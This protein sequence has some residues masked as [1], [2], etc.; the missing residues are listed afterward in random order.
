[1]PSEADCGCNPA[2]QQAHVDFPRFVV[3]VTGGTGHGRRRP[4][5]HAG[6]RPFPAPHSPGG[7]IRVTVNHKRPARKPEY[8]EVRGKV[9]VFNQDG[10]TPARYDLLTMRVRTGA[11]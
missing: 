9:E 11:A 5:V 2:G 7:A 10:E 6:A 4:A 1:M 3:T 8:G